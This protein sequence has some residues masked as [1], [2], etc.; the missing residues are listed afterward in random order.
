MSVI[1]L[2]N[3]TPDKKL[4]DFNQNVDSKLKVKLEYNEVGNNDWIAIMEETIPSIDTIL[5]NPNRFII[6]EEEV[7][8]IEL[9]RRVTVD[10]IKHLSQNTNLIQEITEDDEVKPSKILNVNKEENFETYENKFIYSLIKNMY[11]FIQVKKQLFGSVEKTKDNKDLEYQGTT[12]CG[13][14]KISIT[15]NYKSVLEEDPDKNLDNKI[16]E[17]EEKIKDLMRL[18]TYKII[19]KRKLALVV[20]PI[21]KTNLIL[22]NQHFQKAV[23]LWNY[24]QENFSKNETGELKE[25]NYE[26]EDIIRNYFNETFLFNYLAASS[27]NGKESPLEKEKLTDKLAELMTQKIIN[28]DDDITL[29]KLKDL[30]GDKFVMIKSKP[31]IS[32]TDIAKV[33]KKRIDKYLK[34]IK[35]LK[36]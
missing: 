33:F 4:N 28:I 27:I 21:K 7:V 32:D 6:N 20:S 30:V 34:T 2:L 23:I 15:L 8:K 12:N 16:N 11:T 25:E 17:I 22:K 10:S 9:A 14:E 29:D 3:T 18:E 13:K 1:D 36:I 19:E 24:L 35:E 31:K 26:D 5:R